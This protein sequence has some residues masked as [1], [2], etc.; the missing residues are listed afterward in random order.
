MQALFIGQTY[1][2]VTF[3]TD[4]MPIGD[5]KH[6]AS[7]YAISFGG[8]AV[9][10]AFCCA[11]LGLV[12]ELLATVADDWLGRMFLDMAAKYEIPVHPR[13]VRT[14]SLSFIMPNDGKR[15]IVRC[16]DDDYLD[17]FPRLDLPDCRAVHMDG[18][19]P[20]AAIYHA[21]TAHDAGILT[22]LDGG[23]LRSN[24]HE[25]LAFIDIAIVSER[26]CEQMGL[27]PPRMLDYVKSRGCRIGGVT[28]GERGLV[29]YD[30][31]GTVQTL[32]AL[33]VPSNRVLDTSGAGDVFHGA[34]VYSYLADASKSWEE[35]FRFAR[36]ASAYKIQRLG[37][38]AG[39][40]TFA[41]IATV[42]RE[43]NVGEH[44][45]PSSGQVPQAAY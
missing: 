21:K 16:R 7:A 35:H 33:A 37:N 29:W 18:H 41:D 44:P 5:E 34:Y 14:S 2:D 42:Q 3:L 45:G 4:R 23:G 36:A 13:K 1:I 8:N 19:Q 22:S 10:A 9:T 24:T 20:D 38:E 25:L 17:P 39:L 31:A 40:P 32:P 11:K 28:L 26:L 30:E 6:V 43:F 12:P 15:A 27:E